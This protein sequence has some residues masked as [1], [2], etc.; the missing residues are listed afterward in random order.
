MSPPQPATAALLEVIER[1]GHLVLE[2]PVE[3]RSGARSRHFVDG[4]R[5][6]AR[7]DDL[8]LAANALLDVLRGEGVAFDAVGGMTMGADHLAHA[9]AL[10][11]GDLEWF[12]VRKAAKGR[13]TNRRVEGAALGAGRRAVVVEDV[14]T[15]GG[16]ILE[17]VAAVQATGA[18]VVFALT[19]VDRGDDGTLALAGAGIPYRCLLGYRDLG[20]PAVGSE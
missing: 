5:A 20:I 7:G 18:E 4:K 3:L 15:T 16:S 6:L 19:V 12:S 17:A 2:E 11:D 10:V 13:G 9:M 14:I 1:R 8:R